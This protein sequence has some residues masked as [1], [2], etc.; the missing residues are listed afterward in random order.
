M[1]KFTKLT[2]VCVL[3]LVLLVS[4]SVSSP[5]RLAVRQAPTPDTGAPAPG[6]DATPPAGGATPGATPPAGGAPPA[7][8]PSSSPSSSPTMS[9]S[10]A[11]PSGSS[12]PAATGAA[13]KI[14]SGLSSVVALAALVG[15]FL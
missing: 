8:G 2:F 14:E 12:S 10:A 7:G 1:A 11:G 4:F 5:E 9:A 13:Y 3:V 6:G 15:Y